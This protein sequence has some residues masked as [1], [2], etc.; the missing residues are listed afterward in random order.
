MPRLFV[1]ID[2]PERILDDISSIYEAIPGAKWTEH[3]QLHLTLSFI[4]EVSE[5][6]AEIIERSLMSVKVHSFPIQLKNVG[7]FPP[8]KTPRILWCGVAANEELLRLQSKIE[9]T[10]T[11][12]AIAIE[13][14]KYSPH[15]TIARLNNSPPQ[16]LAQFMATNA[17][18]Q[19]EPFLA[20][21][22]FLYSS[23]LR[24]E[25]AHHIK[26]AVYELDPV[27]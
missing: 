21:E 13:Q 14:R 24:R 11:N 7:F 6:T 22:F 19:T 23:H 1:A 2:L 25:G 16:K 26:E 5:D 8:R 15:I 12:A 20:S 18:F 17:L 3:P 4:G 10:L 27:E 9:R